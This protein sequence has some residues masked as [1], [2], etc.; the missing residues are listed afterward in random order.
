MDQP[1]PLAAQ[2]RTDQPAS[3]KSRLDLLQL[4]NNKYLKWGLAV[5]VL[6]IV[7]VIITVVMGK[8][9]SNDFDC[10]FGYTCQRGWCKS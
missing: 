6:I 8:K 2:Q 9:C 7:V 1:Q 3:K 5:L 10:K 4:H